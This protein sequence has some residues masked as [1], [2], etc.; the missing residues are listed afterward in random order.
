M[1]QRDKGN[2]FGIFFAGAS[3]F[4]RGGP[5]HA[6]MSRGPSLATA[7]MVLQVFEPR[8]PPTRPPEVSRV[9]CSTSSQSRRRGSWSFRI[10]PG[11]APQN[12]H[13]PLRLETEQ[14]TRE[15]SGG[16][17]SGPGGPNTCY[18]IPVMAR[19][20]PRA[21]QTCLGPPLQKLLAPCKNSANS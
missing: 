16:L 12:D 20:G 5:R 7:G 1:R 9:D 3:S 17:V 4:C 10:G 13:E 15:A 6:W 21:I 19:D 14:A 18:T 2:E 8:E 11:S